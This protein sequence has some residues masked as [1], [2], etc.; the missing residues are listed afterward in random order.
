MTFQ[1]LYLVGK[2]PR[3]R[4]PFPASSDRAPKRP[5]FASLSWIAYQPIKSDLD[6]NKSFRD[7]ICLKLLP[8]L[9]INTWI[10]PVMSNEQGAFPRWSHTSAALMLLWETDELEA[11]EKHL[12]LCW[13]HHHYS[14]SCRLGLVP[15]IR[16]RLPLIWTIFRRRRRSSTAT[17][18]SPTAGGNFVSRRNILSPEKESCIQ[19]LAVKVESTIC[20]ETEFHS[21]L[22]IHVQ[23]WGSSRLEWSGS[24]ENS[25]FLSKPKRFRILLEQTMFRALHHDK[26]RGESL[27]RNFLTSSQHEPSN[28]DRTTNGKW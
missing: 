15:L 22:A 12:I 19:D 25:T 26:P 4:R 23:R 6:S 28:A 27:D 16:L 14:R 3:R 13:H 2:V 11:P 24:Q 17:T 8:H 21:I 9:C 18:R 7:M 5:L 10:W 1:R 20:K